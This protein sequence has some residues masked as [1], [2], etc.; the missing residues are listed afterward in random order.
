MSLDA[1]FNAMFARTIWVD[2]LY[3]EWA[4]A[5][6]ARADIRLLMSVFAGV[7]V[8]GIAVA[9]DQVFGILARHWEEGHQPAT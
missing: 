1:P 8:S 9:D 3:D 2:G 5:T 6:S 7:S 4:A